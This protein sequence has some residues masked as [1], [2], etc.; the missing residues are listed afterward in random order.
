MTHRLLTGLLLLLLPAA[1]AAFGQSAPPLPDTTSLLA[2]DTLLAAADTTDG[3]VDTVVVYSAADSLVFTPATRTMSMYGKGEIRYRELGLKAEEIDIDWNTATLH[4]RGVADTSDTSGTGFRGSPVL[5]DGG[6]TYDGA[7]VSYNFRSKKGRITVGKTEIG[8]GRYTGGAIKRVDDGVLFVEHG[9]YTTCEL[10][11]PH[12]YIGSPEMRVNFNSSVVARPV[13]MVIED[14]PVFAL[15]FGVFPNERGRRSGIIMPAY[16]QSPRGRFLQ[17][18]GYYWAISDYMDLALTGD[19]YT[20]GSWRLIGDYRYA[21]R[22]DFSGSLSGSVARTID[23]EPSDPDYQD[24]RTYNIM[25]RHYQQ[26]EP[27]MRLDVDFTWMS[28]DYYRNTSTNFNEILQQNAVSNATLTK[29]WEGTPHSLTVNARRDQVLAG[30]REGEVSE[31]LP[32]VV[33]T[34]TQTFPF[35]AEENAD[36]ASMAWYEYPGWSYTGQFINSR[37]RTKDLT[38]GEFT[39]NDRWGFN[40]AFNLSAA[41]KVGYVTVSPFFNYTERWYGEGVVKEVDP[42]TN[43]V[44]EQKETGFQ[45]VRFYDMGISASTRFFGIVQPGILGIKGIR[46]QVLPSITYTYQPDFAD[47]KYG[48]Y[49]TYTDTSGRTVRYGV[50]DNGVFGGAPAEERQALTVRIGNV[51]EVKTTAPVDTM[52]DPKFQLLNLDV[53]GG[54]NFARDSLKFDPLVLGFR[55]QVG[56][57]LNISGG[58]TYDL[59]RFEPYAENPQSGRRVDQLLWNEGELPDLTFFTLSIGTSFR[60]D[61]QK[62]SAGPVLTPEDSIKRAAGFRDIYY[63]Q[64]P[65][66]TIPWQLDLNWIFSQ[67]EPDPRVVSRSSNL[68]AN[69]SFNL[70]ENWKI[71][72]STSYDLVQR[73]I[74][75]PQ[76]GIY[77]DLHCWEMNF[78]WVPTGINQ[79]YRFEIR[80]K[81]PILQDVKV[82]K[83]AS[84]RNA[85]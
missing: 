73:Q 4:A 72:A 26:F 43:A 59:Y 67:S 57:L 9:R 47:P 83:S 44:V 51:F 66:F 62:S 19:G 14:V 80:L 76:I 20:N 30:D 39:R 34:R 12:Y 18:L 1:P 22:Y 13:Y 2:A 78:S 56:T 17:H 28:S 48:Y 77:R 63:E 38:T 23:N 24:A 32:G 58:A 33:F 65:D 5:I 41:P 84:S 55:T 3:D 61:K 7:M 69:L 27:T 64:V 29:S 6:D 8:D 49:R 79:Y 10:D 75:A 81:N 70:T 16:G 25:F 50:Y 11:H 85:F 68:A 37:Q 45:A 54:Y 15:P 46:H 42:A 40:H 53:A 60:G 71:T 74:A 36:P 52:E 82:T 21:S 35:R 31:L